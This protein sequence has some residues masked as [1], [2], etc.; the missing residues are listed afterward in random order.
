MTKSKDPADVANQQ[1]GIDAR[2]KSNIPCKLYTER[3]ENS[4]SEA[5]YDII[6]DETQDGF[7]IDSDA[8]A[9]WAVRKIAAK[10]AERDEMVSWYKAQ[11]KKAEED[12]DK[13][14]SYLEKLLADYFRTVP[15]KSTK[16][17]DSYTFPGGKLILKTQ[18]PQFNRDE[19]TVIEWLEKNKMTNYVKTEKKLDWDGLKKVTDVFEGT[20]VTEDGEIV[21]GITVEYLEPKFVVEVK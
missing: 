4:M 12:T 20:V 18:N 15:H 5:L 7:V 2:A 17:Q 6:S 9:G 13:S 3:K 19:K 16:T 8:K 11:I 10:R 1:G 14:T 21:P